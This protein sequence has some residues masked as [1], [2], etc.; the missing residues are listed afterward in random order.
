MP[1]PTF[2]YPFNL[3]LGGAV[4]AAGV[5]RLSFGPNTSERWTVS[6]VTIDM[7]TAP[8]GAVCRIYY[9]GRLV[10]ESFSAQSGT[11]GGDPPIHLNGG[12]SM[13]VEWTGATPNAQGNILVVYTKEAY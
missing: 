8:V 11:A 9:M 4:N 10:S 13:Y 7:P 1:K 3:P 5:L 2:P 12:E 6:Q